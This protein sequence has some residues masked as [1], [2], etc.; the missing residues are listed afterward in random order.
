MEVIAHQYKGMHP[1]TRLLARFP[2]GLE[3]HLPI[4]VVAI[5]GLLTIASADHMIHRAGILNSQL[6]S[7]EPIVTKI[8]EFVNSSI[9]GL[10]PWPTL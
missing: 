5:D 8:F 7:H 3:E 1:P 4:P 6:P 9:I 2:E 10:T